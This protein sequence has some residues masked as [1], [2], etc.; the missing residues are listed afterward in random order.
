[1]I[2][3]WLLWWWLWWQHD[4]DDELT[5]PATLLAWAASTVFSHMGTL[6]MMIMMMTWLPFSKMMVTRILALWSL[7]WRTPHRRSSQRWGWRS[8]TTSP[9]P[10]LPGKLLL[11]PCKHS[12]KQVQ[13]WNR[14]MVWILQKKI[15]PHWKGSWSHRLLLWP[16][17]VKLPTQKKHFCGHFIISNINV[18][19]WTESS[20]VCMFGL[21]WKRWIFTWFVGVF[22]QEVPLHLG[23][24]LLIEV[25]TEAP[26]H[27]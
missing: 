16:I 18:E 5:I 9:K 8:W 15:Q 1:M 22:L 10:S 27:S 21:F 20:K 2:L 7:S 4:D 3:L 25:G 14:L 24:N 19:F 26:S 6:L 12:Q 13:P 17:F 23:W 11:R